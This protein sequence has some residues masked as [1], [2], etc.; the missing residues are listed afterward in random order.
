MMKTHARVLVA[1]V[2]ALGM[3]SASCIGASDE[4]SAPTEPASAGE[5]WADTASAFEAEQRAESEEEG[6]AAES[7]PL[8]AEE[9]KA[10]EIEQGLSMIES[11]PDNVVAQGPEAVSQWLKAQTSRVD[12]R[13]TVGCVTAIGAAIVLNLPVLK[14]LK[15]R[16]VLKAVGGA[17]KFTRAAVK[18]YKRFKARGYTSQ[19][20]MK[21]AVATASRHAGPE[22]KQFLID[23]FSLGAV[24]SACFE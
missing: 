2:V 19:K 16:T 15:I 8:S 17:G 13:G 11:I 14:I 22:A 5:A 9:K 21:R 24:F 6:A 12:R 10:R 7:V 18:L 20:A 23:L 3:I 4:G 1:W